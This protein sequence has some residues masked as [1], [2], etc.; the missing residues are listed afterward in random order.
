MNKKF[1]KLISILTIAVLSL[2]AFTACNRGRSSEH[3]EI[4]TLITDDSIMDRYLKAVEGYEKVEYEQIALSYDRTDFLGPTDYTFRGIVYLT[5]EE[6][7]RIQ[8][9]YEWNEVTSPEFE[10]KEVNTSVIGEG[11]WYRCT[12]FEKDN[13]DVAMG[14]YK[15]LFD[16][17]ILVFDMRQA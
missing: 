2:S 10:F 17:E 12:E 6:A 1:V 16:G 9:E 11:P 14:S 8:E 7:S 3:K 5:D 4:V 15:I 13:C